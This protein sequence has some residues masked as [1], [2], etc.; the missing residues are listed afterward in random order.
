MTT[1]HQ[2][3]AFCVLGV[4]AVPLGTFTLIKTINKIWRPAA[5][6]LQRPGDLQ[7]DYI[8]PTR[9][10]EIYYYPDLLQPRYER[11]SDYASFYRN[12][13]SYPPTYRSEILPSYYTE[14][15]LNI[16]CSLENSI[17]LEIISLIFIFMF[18]LIILWK[19]L[20]EKKK[21]KVFGELIR[22]VENIWIVLAIYIMNSLIFYN[23]LYSISIL[24]PFSSFEIDFRDSFEW[25]FNSYGVKSK[26][27]Y[28]PIQT[29]TGD[30]INLLNS[31][32]D[33]EN[34][35]MGLSFIS[36]YN[37]WEDN[38]E[39]IDP[40]FI[41]DAIIVNKYSDPILIT[42]FIMQTLNDKGI[43]IRN[44]LFKDIL[45]NSIDPVIL[46]VTVPIKVEI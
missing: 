36:S 41:D 46:I 40:I 10:Q 24:I 20:N 3:I 33:E 38:K 31:F 39:K 21:K 28:L 11:I 22:K 5:N 2:I 45:I 25:K 6:T 18:F 29:L 37:E 34:Y 13:H 42:Q 43:F 17:N 14:D 35:S 15:R 16:Y 19:I 9:P 32:K 23:S 1:Q 27:S 12:P 44:W 4:I 30:I 26:I 7:L 8:E